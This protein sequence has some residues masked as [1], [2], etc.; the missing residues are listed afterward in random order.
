MLFPSIS[1]RLEDRTFCDIPVTNF[2]S[3]PKRFVLLFKSRK[4]RTFHLSPISI[5][6]VYTG[7]SGSSVL[8]A[9]INFLS[10]VS[11]W[12]QHSYR[13]ILAYLREKIKK[14]FFIE[15]LPKYCKKVPTF[16]KQKSS[17]PETPVL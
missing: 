9:I 7:R 13:Y 8:F 5:S 10:I 12:M 14:N 1:R 2:L 3:S 15:F 4:I 17:P 11:I 16:R 6:V